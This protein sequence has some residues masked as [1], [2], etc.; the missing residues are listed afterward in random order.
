MEGG[1]AIRVSEQTF[2][3]NVPWTPALMHPHK[4]VDRLNDNPGPATP[5]ESVGVRYSDRVG[6][7]NIDIQAGVFS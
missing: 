7:A 4:I 2:H 5:I 3:L 6:C 1:R